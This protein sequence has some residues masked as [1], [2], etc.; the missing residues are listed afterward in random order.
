MPFLI[1]IAGIAAWAYVKTHGANA[2]ADID[3]D[4]LHDD[5]DV[6]EEERAALR[7]RVEALEAI[8]TGEGFE[9]E[10]EARRAGIALDL[11]ALPDAEPAAPQRRRTRA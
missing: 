8:V 9:L 1:P 7:R 3:V 6:A 11:D 5:L 2:S 4:A 10:R